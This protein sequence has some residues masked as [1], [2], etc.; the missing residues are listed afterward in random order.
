MKP[1]TVGLMPE[2]IWRG[3]PSTL[4]FP[5]WV[6]IYKQNYIKALYLKLNGSLL[7]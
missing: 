5:I 6:W 7:E 3:D 1:Q 4:N 2:Q